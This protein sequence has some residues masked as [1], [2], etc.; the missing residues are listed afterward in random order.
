MNGIEFF[1]AL[2]NGG[3]KTTLPE[4]QT[5][6]LKAAH[7][8]ATQPVKSFLPFLFNV[9]R[10]CGRD[11]PSNIFHDWRDGKAGRKEIVSSIPKLIERSDVLDH[12]FDLVQL[13]QL[14]GLFCILRYMPQSDFRKILIEQTKSSLPISESRACKN[15]IGELAELAVYPGD[16][17]IE[18][19]W[20][21]TSQCLDQMKDNWLDNIVYS[22]A[23]L[24]YIR[25]QEKEHKGDSSPCREIALMLLEIYRD[26]KANFFPDKMLPRQ[27][28]H[29]ALWFDFDLKTKGFSIETE[30]NTQSAE[31]DIFRSAFRMAG[32]KLGEPYV[33]K[34]G[35]KFD[36]SAQFK[37]K[38]LAV[39]IDGDTH[40]L[41]GQSDNFL[42]YDGRTRF[43]TALMQKTLP[44]GV[45]LIRVPT[46]HLRDAK[47]LEIPLITRSIID[48][49]SD[50]SGK[51][52]IM[53][54][55]NRF[56]PI[57]QSDCWKLA[58]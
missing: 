31:E 48:R 38:P 7:E 46:V 8:I 52:I 21:R 50:K 40:T 56:V 23:I 33:T 9:A 4:F 39:E 14:L 35:H 47:S 13:N 29:A 25:G 10:L 42:Y 49:V 55:L 57:T 44:F 27:I 2:S 34:L 6:W 18:I 32:A 19:W 15:Y 12:H 17:W 26:N 28:Y 45:R 53:H 37:F 5:H 36:I 3:I 16:D 22:L 20:D 1:Q 54:D 11:T 24:D 43:Q 58:V 41:Q 30:T 51:P